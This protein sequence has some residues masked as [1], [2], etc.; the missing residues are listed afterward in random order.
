MDQNNNFRGPYDGQNNNYSNDMNQNNNMY[1]NGNMPQQNNMYQNNNMYYN[2]RT[3]SGLLY[4]ENYNGNP[5]N[6]PYQNTYNNVPPKTSSLSIVAFILSLLGCT[7]LIG[8]ILGIV[9]LTKGDGRK[10]GLSIAAVVI[11]SL[12]LIGGLGIVILSGGGSKSTSTSSNTSSSTESA[13]STTSEED[14]TTASTSV[15]T[16]ESEDDFKTSCETI[17]YD[18]VS[19]NPSSYE[20][21][22][23]VIGGTVVQ[24]QE[25]EALLSDDITVSLRV[26]EDGDNN[27]IWF[28]N[29]TR[30]DP[31]EGRV[32]EDDYI[33]VYGTCN[34]LRS[35]TSVLGSEITIPEVN[36]KYIAN[37]KV[38]EN[39]NV[40]SFDE[41]EI[42]KNLQVKELIG[43]NDYSTYYF[44]EIEN[45]S[46]YDLDIDAEV[47]YFDD[48]GNLIGT[49]SSSEYA[50]AQG[51]K[52]LMVFY[53]D[54][55]FA[56]AEYKLDVKNASIYKPG[57]DD[58]S[59][60]VSEA[61]E[62]IIVT[63]KNISDETLDSMEGKAL[64]YKDGN[65]VGSDFT[66]F[67]DSD[68]ELKAGDDVTKELNC[69]DGYDSYELYL[70]PR[71]SKY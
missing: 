51:Y 58:I 26:A 7:S 31:N 41:S 42:I 14:S 47:K 34:G 12:A 48:S 61:D 49:D 17:D 27:K 21:K 63:V 54:D 35:Y 59:Y 16:N 37:G 13:N 67:T 44:L 9:D 68:A 28:V 1:Q 29:Y 32:L 3:P 15:D 11:S 20:G 55:N 69:Y 64:F 2:D 5:G 4:N 33:T 70:Y 22:R 6:I 52:A 18:D 10:K 8:L 30:T 65:V 45:T 43:G 25:D 38:D 24:V 23:M 71:K 56:K 53:P 19:R 57:N 39:N 60:E 46:I 40:V 66:Y 62:K 36:A 50:I